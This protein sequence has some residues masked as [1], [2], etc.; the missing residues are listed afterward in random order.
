MT[1]CLETDD[2]LRPAACHNFFVV[3]NAIQRRMTRPPADC[4]LQLPSIIG[5]GTVRR[6][7]PGQIAKQRWIGLRAVDDLE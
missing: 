6:L 2:G 5:L 1:G 4:I 7:V 3:L